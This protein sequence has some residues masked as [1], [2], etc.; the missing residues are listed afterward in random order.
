MRFALIL[1]A[2]LLVAAGAA[3]YFHPEWFGEAVRA[4]TPEAAPQVMYKWQDARGQWVVSDTPP[5]DGV[6][7][8]AVTIA[9]NT[10][11]MPTISDD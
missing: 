2:L 11:V 8:E 4:V 7:Y 10:N 1:I 3:Y 5:E 9:P 6:A